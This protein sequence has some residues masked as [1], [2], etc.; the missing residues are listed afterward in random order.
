[1]N[2]AVIVILFIV[3]LFVL[4]SLHELGHFVTAK[5]AGVKVEEFGLGL[6]PRLFGIKRGETIYSINAIPLGAFVKTPGENDPKVPR[7]LASR[8]PWS[9]LGIYA[10]GPLAN[11]FLAFILL[12]AFFMLPTT[13]VLGNGVMVHSIVNDSPAE[14]ASIEPGD[15]I[16]EVDGKRVHTWKD[17]QNMVNSSQEGEEITLVLQR[18]GE[19]RTKSLKPEF[20][21]ALQR[22]VLGVL[23]CWNMVSHMEEDSPLAEAGIRPG[24]TILSINEKPIYNRESMSNVLNSIGE[25]EEINLALLRGQEE[26]SASLVNV[27]ASE[28]KQSTLSGVELRWV[29][30]THIEQLHFPIWKAAY[31]G[32]SYIIHMPSM[33]IDAISVIKADPGKALVGPIG[34]GQLTVEA[35]RLHGFSNVLF[36]ASII[37]L[38]LAL[39]NL[40]PIPPLDGGGMLVAL[41]EGVRR[42]KRL[43][44]RAVRL[45]YVIGTTLLITLMVVVTFSDILRLIRGESFGL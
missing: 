20:D 16:L 41:I 18:E 6:P 43:S 31:F 44:P 40:L 23:L 7:S 8:G 1:M 17:L 14:E 15:I 3:S 19:A 29:D 30:G 37:S 25:G 34:A 32:G 42:G 27:I 38:G 13:I 36:M 10:A 5:R 2:I 28:A 11:I 4:I 39:F 9:R 26:V 33:L 22:Q 35:V 12:S 45:A 24:D 21:S